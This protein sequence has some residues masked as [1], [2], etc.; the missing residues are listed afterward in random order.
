MGESYASSQ[1]KLYVLIRAS[2]SPSPF[3]SSLHPSLPPPPL[4]M[5]PFYESLCSEVG[6]PV[7]SD[8]LAELKAANSEQLAKLDETIEDSEK[9]FGETE[10][11]EALQAKAEYLCRIGDKAKDTH[12]PLGNHTSFPV[13]VSLAHSF[14][15]SPLTPHPSLFTAPLVTHH[16][17]PG[18][19]C[20]CIPCCL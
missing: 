3:L 20:V 1:G 8:L 13:C 12:R 5:A 15:P 10:Q 7:D 17:L 6:R 19:S 11:K 2:P 14:P 16:F 18:R 9:N 4:A